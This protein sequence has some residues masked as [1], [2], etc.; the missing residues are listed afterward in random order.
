M[1]ARWGCGTH[2]C[3]VPWPWWHR[4]RQLQ[5]LQ[6]YL[7]IKTSIHGGLV[8]WSP[9]SRISTL[10]R[11]AHV[12]I[13]HSTLTQVT[14]VQ[15]LLLRTLDR[16]MYERQRLAEMSL[17]RQCPGCWHQRELWAVVW[18]V[19]SHKV[20]A[21]PVV[22]TISW[23]PPCHNQYCT[24]Y[25]ITNTLPCRLQTH[26]LM[27]LFTDLLFHFSSLS[28]QQRK[29]NFIFVQNTLVLFLKQTFM[30]IFEAKQIISTALMIENP[31]RRPMVPPIADSIST[32]FAA[33]SLV[34]LSNVGVSKQ[35]LT[36]LNL[37]FHS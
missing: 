5:I 24:L 37:F 15:G 34:I 28:S 26:C 3:C 30:I 32:N 19:S 2:E 27:Y 13:C 25:C 1:A 6:I 11:D 9:A 17:M 8:T 36:N 29:N 14:S 10:P 16:A 22:A 4:D 21:A 35:I 7:D 18:T 12:V 23:S 31:V 20:E 33:L